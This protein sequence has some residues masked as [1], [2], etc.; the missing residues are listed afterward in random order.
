MKQLKDVKEI[1]EVSDVDQLQIRDVLDYLQHLKRYGKRGQTSREIIFRFYG[2]IREQ[3][4]YVQLERLKKWG[5]IKEVV[6]EYEPK[7]KI[8]I[9]ELN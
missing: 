6:V 3:S 7:K 8:I 5:L 1:R 2:V 4:V 9:Y